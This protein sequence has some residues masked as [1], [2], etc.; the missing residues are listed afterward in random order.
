MIEDPRDPFALIAPIYARLSHRGDASALLGALQPRPDDWVLDVGGGTG[1]V[2]R[3]LLASARGVVVVDPSAAML[4]RARP[5]PGVVRARAAAE[6]LPFS[7][8]AFSRIVVID[9]FHHFASR[10]AA[11]RELWRVLA[12]GGRLVIEEPDIRHRAVRAIAFGEWLMRFG[13]VFWDPP[14]IAAAF[15]YL[16]AKATVLPNVGY[17]S[18]VLVEKAG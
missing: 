4:R 5:E 15:T 14:R 10:P 9:A 6:A 11:T 16:G 12:P 3:R 1:R 18:H 8:G 7:D 2:A 17:V 13:S